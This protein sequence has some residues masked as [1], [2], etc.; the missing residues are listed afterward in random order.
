MK[1]VVIEVFLQDASM[2]RRLKIKKQIEK[3]IERSDSEYISINTVSEVGSTNDPA[4][5]GP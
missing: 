3:V 5:Q 4:E 1:K 2:E